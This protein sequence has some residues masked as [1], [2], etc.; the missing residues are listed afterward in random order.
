MA[1]PLCLARDA[2][3]ASLSTSTARAK[4]ER[5]AMASPTVPTPAPRS[6]RVPAPTSPA[7][8]ASSTAS[9]PARCPLR[10]CVRVR[11]PPKR[12]STL[13]AL[14]VKPSAPKGAPGSRLASVDT[15]LSAKTGLAQQLPRLLRLVCGDKQAA[16]QGPDRSFEDAHIPVCNENMDSSLLKEGLDGAQKNDVI[17]ADEFDH[18]NLVACPHGPVVSQFLRVARP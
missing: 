14:S 2:S 13:S 18:H 4:G 6:T 12:A 7:A 16:L 9:V 17:G 1:E 10:G 8:A 15:Q 5:A 3:P 11:R